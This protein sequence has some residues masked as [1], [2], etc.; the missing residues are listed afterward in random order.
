M[1]YRQKYV[2]TIQYRSYMDQDTQTRMN[3]RCDN[4]D[5]FDIEVD[6]WPSSAYMDGIP[7]LGSS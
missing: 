2:T 6:R 4:S 7:G 1:A 3:T 5:Y